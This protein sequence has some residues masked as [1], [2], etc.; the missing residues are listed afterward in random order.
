MAALKCQLR[1]PTLFVSTLIVDSST[2]GVADHHPRCCYSVDSR[3]V[4]GGEH[5]SAFVS[6]LVVEPLFLARVY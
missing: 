3:V 6:L 2:L 4:S 5:V 1:D